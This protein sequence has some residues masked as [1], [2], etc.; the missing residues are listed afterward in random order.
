M[1]NE[2]GKSDKPILPQ[3]SSNNA[4]QPGAEGMEGRGL[5]KG[6][7]RQQNTFRTQSRGNVPSALERVREAAGKNKGTKFTALFHYVYDLGMAG[8]P[9]IGGRVI[10]ACAGTSFRVGAPSFV[11]AYFADAKGGRYGAC[12]RFPSFAALALCLSA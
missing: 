5:A 7:P 11:E 10:L 3:K 12:K 8:G 6:K 2:H 9:A 4:G 1:M